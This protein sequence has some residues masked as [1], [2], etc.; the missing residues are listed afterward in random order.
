M[1][2]KDFIKILSDKFF[3][4]IVCLVLNQSCQQEISTSPPQPEPSNTAKIFVVSNPKGAR[5]YLND[6]YSGHKTPDT[7]KWLEEGPY[8][9]TLK[10]KYYKD[11]TV[12]IYIRKDQLVEK[13]IDYTSNPGMLGSIYC[14]TNPPGAQVILND[15][16]TNKITPVILNRVLP[17][18]HELRF[19]LAGYWDGKTKVTVNSSTTVSAPHVTL[20]DTS[21]WIQYTTER[22]PLPTD[23]IKH[24]AIEKG[25]IKWIATPNGV[26]R[27]DDNEWTIFNID[28]S[29]LPSNNINFI[30]IDMNDVKWFCTSGGLVKFDDKN[31]FVYN[32]ANSKLPSDEINCV[33]VSTSNDLIII[34]TNNGLALFN[35]NQWKIFNS[36]NSKLLSNIITSVE[37]DEL[38]NVKWIGT[39]SGGIYK[40]TAIN[41]KDIEIYPNFGPVLDDSPTSSSVED[42]NISKSGTIW[43]AIRF[44]LGPNAVSGIAYFDGR[45]FRLANGPSKNSN[46]IVF[47]KNDN[48]WVSSYTDGV[49]KYSNGNF[50][51]YS[52]EN[53]H[54]MSNSI[55]SIAI[56]DQNNKW[57]ATFGGGLVKYK[58]D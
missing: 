22:T 32:T 43:I 28:N 8:K 23:Y 44:V 6:E 58:G 45:N 12:Y 1:N 54:L 36:T 3:I 51:Q 9:L 49:F 18:E 24:I 39:I 21:I 48:I 38:S 7:I 17:G 57:F 33:D 15:S 27:Y 31:W 26:T 29:P 56:D 55:F 37:L 47:D 5:I 50:I 34:G 25:F 20:I 16:A 30:K 13:Y 41:L 53:S 35:N 10:M 52:T 19:R 46:S 11:T 42:I 14:R 40:F 2:A 4:S